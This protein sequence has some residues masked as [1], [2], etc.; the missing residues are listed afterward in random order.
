MESNNLYPIALSYRSDEDILQN[1]LAAKL[2]K[3]LVSDILVFF[4]DYCVARRVGLRYDNLYYPA[5]SSVAR[6]VNYYPIGNEKAVDGIVN[7]AL[8]DT[9]TN[10]YALDLRE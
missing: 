7:M 6:S 9:Q 2:P 8:K 4:L 3:R 1:F 10:F 5:I